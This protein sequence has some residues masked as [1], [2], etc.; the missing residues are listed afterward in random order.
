MAVKFAVGGVDTIIGENPVTTR[1]IVGGLTARPVHAMPASDV[2]FGAGV[3]PASVIVKL[4]PASS[5]SGVSTTW[6]QPEN[7]VVPASSVTAVD[8]SHMSP[9]HAPG[10]PRSLTLLGPVERTSFCA[11]AGRAQPPH[12]PC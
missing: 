4:G 9:T 2:R 5:P 12:T 10:R 7:P 6:L 11:L 1:L 3:S 8:G